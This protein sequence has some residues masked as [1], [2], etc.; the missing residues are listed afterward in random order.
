MGEQ[1]QSVDDSRV[2]QSR[3]PDPGHGEAAVPRAL[4]W[5]LCAAV[6]IKGV[7]L[8]QYAAL[9]ILD[10]PAFDSLAY[11]RQARAIAAG[12]FGD[13]SLVAF[14]P[15]YGYLLALIGAQDNF[16]RVVVLQLVLGCFNLVLIYQIAE[17]L[18]GRRA[19]LVTS[20]LY[21]GYGLLAFYET[22]VLA[23]TLGLTLS[24][25]AFSLLTSAA[26]V[27]GQVRST[28]VA[29][30]VLALA[31]LART[32]LLLVVPFVV[33]ALLV[34]VERDWSTAVRRALGCVLGLC[35]VFGA[36]GAWNYRNTGLFVPVILTSQTATRASTT[37]WN[38]SIAAFSARD[39]GQV[40]VFDVLRQAQARIAGHAPAQAAGIDVLGVL[41]GAPAKLLATARNVETDFQYGYYGERSEVSILG[42]LSVSFG[43]LEALALLGVVALFA[44]SRLRTLIPLAPWALGAL[45][46]TVLFH[47]SSR[48]RLP[49]VLPL[50][51]LAGVGVV[52]LWHQPRNR[53]FWSMA[54]PVVLCGAYFTHATVNYQ[55]NDPAMWHLRM[56]E[57]AIAAWDAEEAER[58]ITRAESIAGDQPH[59]QKRIAYLRSQASGRVTTRT[60]PRRK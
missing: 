34:P 27:R 25:V 51:M 14:S 35:L 48:Y 46:T 16:A 60:P 23:E 39:D 29:G 36:N 45:A 20:T 19:A 18:F 26:V 53:R 24:L 28:I 52:W 1:G 57:S 59:I 40:G 8:V 4:L 47:P 21:L 50:L 30:G 42:L 11:L 13:A 33:A 2:D 41:R 44:T 55:L 49:L 5:L 9:P 38:G 15:L 37:T 43:L 7:Y 10:G 17:R 3:V 32:N 56:A 6:V 12:R 31:V 22:K 54:L 58:R